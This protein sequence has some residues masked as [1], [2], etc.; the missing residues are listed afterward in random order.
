[1]RLMGVIVAWITDFALSRIKTRHGLHSI[2]IRLSVH[3]YDYFPPNAD[4]VLEHNCLNRLSNA[5]ISQFN[6]SNL[7]TRTE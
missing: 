6:Q 4:V 3:D 5:T 2:G 7:T 1:M